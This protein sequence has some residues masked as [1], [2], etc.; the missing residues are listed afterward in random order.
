MTLGG[1]G[2]SMHFQIW[3]HLHFL[4]KNSYKIDQK[5][6][7]VVSIVRGYFQGPGYMSKKGNWDVSDERI[8]EK[9]WYIESMYNGALISGFM[10]GSN[11]T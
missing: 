6:G 1:S 11:I 2:S 8:L 7:K 9:S 3:K 10:S 4:M 5:I